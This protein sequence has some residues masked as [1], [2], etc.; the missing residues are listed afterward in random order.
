MISIIGAGPAG[1]YLASLLAKK[2][3][4]EI[5][6]EHKEVGKPFQCTGIVTS[7]I[8][9]YIKLPKKLVLTKIKNIDVY[10]PD[11]TKLSFKLKNPD[12]II[13]RI[14]FDKFLANKAVKSGAKLN[15]NHKYIKNNTKE[16]E[17]KSKKKKFTHLIGADGPFSQVAKNN[18]LYKEREFMTGYQARINHKQDPETVEVWL[19]I[20]SF[21]WIVPENNKIVRIG[22]VTKEDPKPLFNKLLKL[23]NIK[24][25][26]IHNYQSGLIPIYNPKQQV[27]KDNIY[28]VGDSATQVKASTLGGII[29]GL[30][31][32]HKI[33][34]SIE[35]NKPY[36]NKDKELYT[37][38]KI[39]QIMGKFKENNYNTLLKDLS[40]SK[41]LIESIDRDNISKIVPKLL[42][43]NPKLI[44]YSLKLI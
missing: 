30:R 13:D 43:T 37:H 1:S 40:K 32:A 24:S 18:N 27:K 28:L 5:F 39:S 7:S 42:L 31:A 38:L 23:K 9:D 4:V 17:L 34:Q 33:K 41:H 29:P 22:L 25:P 14:G 10:P 3:N 16:I 26:K 12:L 15:L 20:G 8:Q 2:H 35:N 36:T 19:G 44:K 21:A 11:K 6:E